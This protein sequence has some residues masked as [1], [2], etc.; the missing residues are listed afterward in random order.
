MLMLYS[1]PGAPRNPQ[2][3][4]FDKTTLQL[5]WM[6]PEML[7]GIILYYR[8]SVTLLLSVYIQLRCYENNLAI[9]LIF[10]KITATVF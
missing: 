4:T 9:P 2:V 8:V 3:I 10:I 1:V 5:Q 7:N 6:E